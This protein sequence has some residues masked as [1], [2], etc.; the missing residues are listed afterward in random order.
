MFCMYSNKHPKHVPSYFYAKQTDACLLVRQ[1]EIQA[2]VLLFQDAAEACY[3][4]CQYWIVAC[5]PVFRRLR[6]ITMARFDFLGFITKIIH[7][8]AGKRCPKDKL[9]WCAL[10]FCTTARRHNGLRFRLGAA[11]RIWMFERGAFI[12]IRHQ[13]MHVCLCL[14]SMLPCFWIMISFFKIAFKMN[15][16]GMLAHPCITRVMA[17]RNISISCRTL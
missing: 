10:I 2:C 3:F 1:Y 8:H 6:L 9:R 4:M 7:F 12:C 15:R 16:D 14:H 17:S 11:A 5:L 13:G